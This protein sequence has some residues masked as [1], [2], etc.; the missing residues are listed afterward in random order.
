[1]AAAAAICPGQFPRAADDLHA[2]WDAGILFTAGIGHE[3]AYALQLARSIKPADLPQWRV[4]S[5]ATWAI[6]TRAS[7]QIAASLSHSTRTLCRA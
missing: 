7:G 4:C 6:F 3:C 5:A 1:M 2:V